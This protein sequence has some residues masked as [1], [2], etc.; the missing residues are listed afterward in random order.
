MREKIG[1]KELENVTGGTEDDT[2]KMV[3]L[4]VLTGYG[5]FTTKEGLD[6]KV[7]KNFFLSKCYIFI[8]REMESDT[9]IS[10][11]DGTIHD[12]DYMVNLILNNKL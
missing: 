12:H 11:K 8:P 5:V 2:N 3:L 10:S 9:Y 4:L 7:L 1:F 6:Y